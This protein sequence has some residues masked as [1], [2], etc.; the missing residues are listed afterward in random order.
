MDGYINSVT[1]VLSVEEDGICSSMVYVII[2]CQGGMSVVEY[3]ALMFDEVLKL[4]IMS[5]E[6][7]R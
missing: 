6:L 1:F 4:R 5:G 2:V 7:N 3:G